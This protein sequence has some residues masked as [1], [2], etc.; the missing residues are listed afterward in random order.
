MFAS[1]RHMMIHHLRASHPD[2][3]ERQVELEAA[4]RLS[5]GAF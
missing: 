5:H 3:D 4:H 2:W 1:A